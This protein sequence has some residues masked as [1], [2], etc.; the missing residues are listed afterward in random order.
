MI[1]ETM[2]VSG[3]AMFVSAPLIGRLMVK[4]DL[5][6]MIGAGLLVFALGSWMMTQVTRDYDFWELFVPQ[7]LRG[8]GIMMAMVPV[9]NIALG[10]LEPERL[11]NAAGLFNLTRNL[12]GALG[13]ALINTILDGRTD[14]HISRLHDNVTWG[15]AKAV[16]TLN[17]FTQ[18]FQGMGDAS[19]MALKQLNQIVHR[20]AAVMSYAD[21]FYLLALFYVALSV[22]VVLVKRPNPGV[23]P[24]DAH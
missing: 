12:G 24:T 6:F 1:G 15:N 7:I 4:I 3:L 14:H 9:N 22:F 20:Q 8:L 18:R 5:R 19:M 16:E 23:A 11:K 21:A 2:F 17:S 13:L 10:T